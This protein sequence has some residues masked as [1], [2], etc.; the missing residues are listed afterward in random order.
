MSLGVEDASFA[1]CVLGLDI[2]IL[3]GDSQQLPVLELLRPGGEGGVVKLS[4]W[5][6]CALAFSLSS[7]SVG[8]MGC[9]TIPTCARER[10]YATGLSPPSGKGTSTPRGA[11]G[12]VQDR[13]VQGSL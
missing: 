11:S 13:G 6:R 4:T 8:S 10:Q 2:S 5:V 7:N 9:A 1:T 3:S 12:I